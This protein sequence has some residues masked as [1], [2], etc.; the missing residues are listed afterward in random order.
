MIISSVLTYWFS[1]FSVTAFLQVRSRDESRQHPQGEDS[2]SLTKTLRCCPGTVVQHRRP[3]S[4][5]ANLPGNVSCRRRNVV[6][7]GDEMVVVAVGALV[8]PP[9]QVHRLHL[10][11]RTRPSQLAVECHTQ[12][13]CPSSHGERIRHLSEKWLSDVQLARFSTGDVSRYRRVNDERVRLA[14]SPLY[15]FLNAVDH[16]GRPERGHARPQRLGERVL[17]RRHMSF[18]HAA[19]DDAVRQV[20]GEQF[21]GGADASGTSASR[22]RASGRRGPATTTVVVAG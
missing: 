18:H 20:G 10:T 14:A 22:R 6:N 8:A 19:A 15:S 12:P 1:A 11:G 4:L 21:H 16:P 9:A 2:G 7:V 13:P 17:R 3:G 5:S